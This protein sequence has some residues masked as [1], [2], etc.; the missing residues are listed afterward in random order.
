MMNPWKTEVSFQSRLSRVLRRLPRAQ[1]QNSDLLL[2]QRA[3]AR[4][5]PHAPGVPHALAALTPRVENS[6]FRLVQCDPWSHFSWDQFSARCPLPLVS[7]VSK[8]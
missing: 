6:I 1:T 5:A 7:T 2:K 3:A 8:Y 4:Y